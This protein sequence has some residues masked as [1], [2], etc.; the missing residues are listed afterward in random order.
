MSYGSRR[1]RDYTR[2]SGFAQAIPVYPDGSV[3]WQ[4]YNGT[5]STNTLPTGP[6]VANF[7]GSNATA[8]SGTFNFTNA[9]GLYLFICLPKYF[10]LATT[11]SGSITAWTLLT[12]SP[13][14]TDGVGIS[15]NSD[16]D[17]PLEVN[18]NGV[19]VQ[20]NVYVSNSTSATSNPSISVV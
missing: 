16:T 6:T 9:T 15:G 7:T 8:I 14:I 17:V 2:S 4:V 3:I 13:D 10:G 18:V 19:L 1:L 12:P 20:Y 5:Q 11:F